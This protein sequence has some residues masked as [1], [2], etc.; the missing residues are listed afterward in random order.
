MTH[1]QQLFDI[2]ADSYGIATSAQAKEEDISDAPVGAVSCQIAWK[3]PSAR[4][5]ARAT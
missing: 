5:D 4:P 1:Y 3:M 2:A